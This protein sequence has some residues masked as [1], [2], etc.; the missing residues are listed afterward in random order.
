MPGAIPAGPHTPLPRVA[1]LIPETAFSYFPGPE[2]RTVPQ[3]TLLVPRAGARSVLA[4][5]L[6]RRA[7]SLHAA[8]VFSV[9]WI[10][11]SNSEGHTAY[12]L[13]GRDAVWSGKRL[14]RF[15]KI[16]LPPS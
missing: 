2:A 11:G 3:Q 14:P 16:V 9:G 13:P 7:R 1:L 10:C 4:V 6:G 8:Y 15:R 5:G 12:Y